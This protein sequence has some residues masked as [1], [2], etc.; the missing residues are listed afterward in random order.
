MLVMTVLAFLLTAIDTGLPYKKL[1]RTGSVVVNLNSFFDKK[2]GYRWQTTRR[3][4]RSV[5]IT[6]HGTIPYVR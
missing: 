1:H 2:L 6:K 4:Y 5:K 3:V